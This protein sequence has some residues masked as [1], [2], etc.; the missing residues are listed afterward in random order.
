MERYDSYKDMQQPM[1][2]NSHD[3]HLDTDYA[4]W[5]AKVKHRYRSAQVKAAVKVNA[6]KL[7]WNW[8]MGRD[9]VQ[10]MAEE[11]WGAG[12]VEQVSLDLQKEFPNVDGFSVSNLWRM[13]QWFLFYTSEPEKL[14]QGVRELQSKENQEETKLAWGVRDIIQRPVGDFLSTKFGQTNDLCYFCTP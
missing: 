6:E 10:K 8:Q 13:K 14:A 7:L 11:R 3:I 5:I 1:M 2:V 9:L 12:V 4:E